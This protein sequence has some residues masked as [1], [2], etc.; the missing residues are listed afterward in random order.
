MELKTILAI[1]Y[2]N[3]MENVVSKAVAIDNNLD[4]SDIKIIRSNVSDDKLPKEQRFA[5]GKSSGYLD[6]P[7]I[8][9]N[10]YK[11]D[12]NYLVQYPNGDTTWKTYS[13]YNNNE[14]LAEVIMKVNEEVVS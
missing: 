8:G 14:K 2:A 1:L 10:Q 7:V 9:Y 11:L 6:L 13:T 12:D 4:K 5:N 3:G